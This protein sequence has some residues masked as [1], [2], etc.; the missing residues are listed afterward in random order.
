MC[1]HLYYDL[2]IWGCVNLKPQE[3]FHGLNCGD[4]NVEARIGSERWF[5]DVLWVINNKSTGW[6]GIPFTGTMFFLVYPGVLLM[7]FNPHTS[8]LFQSQWWYC[9]HYIYHLVI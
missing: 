1:A 3:G 9:K 2:K 5:K 7:R 6:F 4:R 8:S